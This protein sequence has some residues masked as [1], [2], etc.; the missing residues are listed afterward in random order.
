MKFSIY[1]FESGLY[2]LERV[3]WPSKYHIWEA[4]N[5]YI[6]MKFSIY[7]FES[8]IYHLERII[9]EKLYICIILYI[10]ILTDKE[11]FG[12]RLMTQKLIFWADKW[13]KPHVDLKN[14][15]KPY[16]P[17]TQIIS[18]CLFKKHFQYRKYTRFSTCE[19]NNRF[20]SFRIG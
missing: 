19:L 16:S 12:M 6:F 5:V 2:H 17:Y 14:T 15:W 10:C 1:I 7:I 11:W 18:F 9:C 13:N 3:L 8:R 20:H 4:K